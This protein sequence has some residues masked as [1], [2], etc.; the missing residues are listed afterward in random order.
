MVLFTS[1]AATL[2]ENF[3][4]VEPETK[5]QQYRIVGGKNA[6]LAQWPFLVGIGLRDGSPFCGGSMINRQWV[7]TAAHC[8]VPQ[9]GVLFPPEKLAV[10]R[11][12]PDGL[13]R[14]AGARV[15]AIFAHPQYEARPRGDTF[16]DVALMR[17]ASPMNLETSKLP[18]LATVQTEDTWAKPHVCAAVAGWGLTNQRSNLPLQAVE[19]PI[20]DQQA[21]RNALVEDDIQPGPHLCAG[22]MPGGRDSCK[23]DSGGPLVVWAGPTGFLQVGVVSFG[24]GCARKNK[25]GVYARVSTYHDW[26]FGQ[27]NN[28]P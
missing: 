21:C 15:A 9:Q 22:Y 2:G 18:V 28:N 7:L 10:Y 24:E 20:I 19:L 17:L 5:Q 4:C 1:A 13:P 12:G 27:I 11:A 23:G 8:V 16:N 25:P 6:N 14:G 3:E 26:I